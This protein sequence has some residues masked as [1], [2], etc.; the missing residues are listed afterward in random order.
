VCGYLVAYALFLDRGSWRSRALSLAPYALAVIGWRVVYDA[1]GYGAINSGIYVDPG[2][3]PLE[4][5]Q[6]LVVRLP[7]L[8]LAQLALPLSDLWEIYPFIA[9]WLQPAVLLLTG[10]LLTALFFVFRPL[11]RRDP[12]LRFWALGCVLSTIPV[13]ATFPEDRLLTATA[14]GGS[15]LIASVLLA[16]WERTY[17]RPSR[18]VSACSAALFVIHLALAPLLHVPRT[19]SIDQ[20]D[21]LMLRADESIAHGA[22]AA[23]KTVVLL[24]P[25]FAPFAVYFLPFRAAHGVTLPEHFRWLAT[26]ES[27]LTIER[28]D[29]RTLKITPATGFLSTSSQR[30]FRRA[31]RGF[32]LGETVKLSD[33][34]F[35]VTRL[36]RDGRPAEVTARFQQELESGS[37]QWLQW[38]KHEY[39]PFDL[40]ALGRSVVIPAV[41]QTAVWSG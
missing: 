34:T 18:W 13:C 1:L 35:Q 6:V 7:V 39:V 2:R 41:D 17:P 23:E 10:A 30:M 22:E 16:V 4:F 3:E 11:L 21:K 31:E 26:G 9:S 29:A 12:V 15:P 25:P 27:E 32:K 36:T 28:L 37:I 20:F 14:L 38:G 24:N 5:L 8:L 40:P 33:V 19:L